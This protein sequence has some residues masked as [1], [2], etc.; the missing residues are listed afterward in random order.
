MLSIIFSLSNLADPISIG[1][2]PVAIIICL[3]ST[4]SVVPSDLATSTF[5]SLKTF[6]VPRIESTLF[7]TKRPEM[8]SVNFFT[9]E[10]FLSI[11]SAIS[12]ST[13]EIPIP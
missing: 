11:I 1:E 3:D 5:P 9:I 7:P 10:F 12:K 4:I 8:P 13:F 6:P 2:E